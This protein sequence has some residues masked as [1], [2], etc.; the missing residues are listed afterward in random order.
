MPLPPR[1]LAI[2]TA[3]PKAAADGTAPA[4]A[5]EAEPLM[6]VPWTVRRG[7]SDLRF[8]THWSQGEVEGRFARWTAEIRFAPE[9]LSSSH[10]RVA[11]DLGSVTTNNQD[12]QEAL[13]G[14]DWFAAS[15]HPTATFTA[16]RF[17]H[18]AGTHYIARGS[19]TLRGITLP[20]DLPFT[21]QISDGIAKMSATVEIDRTAFGVGQG[22]WRATD[23][24]PAKVQVNVRLSADRN[25]TKGDKK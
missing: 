1:P 17:I 15:L 19:L 16:D 5:V 14:E 23:D 18:A 24:V 9:A 8:Q 20:L 2:A 3:T 11:V 12:T 4:A 7:S 21:L 6:A 13:P 22:E 25:T 10:V